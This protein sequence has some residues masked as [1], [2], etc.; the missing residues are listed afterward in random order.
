MAKRIKACAETL[1]ARTA[2]TE[3]DFVS[4]GDGLRSVFEAATDLARVIDETTI[5]IHAVLADNHFG[6]A[7]GLVAETLSSVQN[8]VREV[9]REVTTLA[10]MMVDL[11]GMDPQL[12]HLQRICMFL[13]ST[14]VGFAVESSRTTACRDAFGSFV[15]EV[16]GLAAEIGAVQKTVADELADACREEAA[17]IDE[18]RSG[19]KTMRELASR[20]ERTT[21]QAAADVQGRLDQIELLMNAT[22]QR[23]LVLREQAEGAIYHMQFGDI[24]RQ[25]NEHIVMALEGVTEVLWRAPRGREAHAAAVAADHTLAIQIGQL[26][27]VCEELDSAQ[28]HLAQAFAQIAGTVADFIAPLRERRGAGS[29]GDA[30]RL[31]VLKSDFDQLLD[32]DGRSRDLHSRA[33]GTADHAFTTAARLGAQMQKVQSINLDMHLLAL[34]ATVKTAALGS[35]GMTLEVLSKQIHQ[36]YR[37]A[38]AAVSSVVALAGRLQKRD[39]STAVAPALPPAELG[40]KPRLEKGVESVRQ[41]A[42]EFDEMTA[43]VL[44]QAGRQDELLAGTTAKLGALQAFT[45]Q[46]R[47]VAGELREVRA[48]LA[49]LCRARKQGA[50]VAAAEV[51]ERYTM[52]AERDVHQRV[53]AERAS[54][55]TV[56]GPSGAS[57]P[58]SEGLGPTPERLR[59]KPPAEATVPAAR[60]GVPAAPAAPGSLGDNVELF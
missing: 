9:D 27:A 40:A 30:S 54:G 43:T 35:E 48:A 56:R 24:T 13:Q 42:T 46:L 12:A 53:A 11:V 34:N 8:G 60:G 50:A 38:D 33:T 49:P 6:G 36:L 5:R 18:L 3:P 22:R 1:A 2:E 52:Q 55:A 39:D 29:N 14:A 10:T 16:R 32:L 4:L 51:D 57:V 20:L 44:E 21:A 37:D 15:D 59:S 17:R 58:K 31:G 28:Q 25:K 45:E 19:L 26:D 7:D 41:A 47:E 23:S